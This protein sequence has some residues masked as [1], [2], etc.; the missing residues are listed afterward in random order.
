MTPFAAF[1]SLRLRVDFVLLLKADSRKLIALLQQL[2]QR[3]TPSA[4]A[5]I[6][7]GRENDKPWRAAI[8]TWQRPGRCL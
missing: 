8:R 3:H 1:A 4:A 5:T 7:P 2:Q 6:S